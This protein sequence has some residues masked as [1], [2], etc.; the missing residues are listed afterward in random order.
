MSIR[1]KLLLLS[2]VM[3]SIPYVGFQYLRETERYLQSSLEESL[4]SVV[5]AMSISMQF[6]SSIFTNSVDELSSHGGLFVHP[7]GF[8]I[9][10]DGYEDE[11][12]N[13]VGWSESF[14]VG[15]VGSQ[16]LSAYSPSLSRFKL[17]LGE[18]GEYLYALLSV[19]DS[20]IRYADPGKTDMQADAIEVV[21]QNAERE[22]ETLLL[23]PATPG[24]VI[25]YKVVENWDFS[26]SRKTVN[27]VIGAWQ[28]KEG[29]YVVEVRLP[30]H[31]VRS[32]LGFI[33][34]DDVGRDSP[35]NADSTGTS[36]FIA[37]TNGINT[38]SRPNRLLRN[39]AQLKQ[40]IDRVGLK[41]G[42][43]V[44]VLNRNGQVLATSGSLLNE[45]KQGAINFLYTWI[46]P[47]PTSSF[48]DELRRASRLQGAEVL[49]ALNGRAASR[50]RSSP[51][52]RAVIVSAAHPVRAGNELVGA[53]MVEE[54]TNS[55]Q[56]LQRDAMASLYNK[57]ILVIVFATGVIMLFA[58]RL[59]YRILRL[60]NTAESA[61]D[62]QGRIVGDIPES[63]SSDEIGDLSRSFT[64][65]TYRLKEYHDY[66]ESMASKLSHE[67][68]TPISVVSSSLDNLE[69]FELDDEKSRY[70]R[71]VREGVNRLQNLV[72]RLSE[73]ARLEQAISHAEKVPLDLIS[74]LRELAESYDDTYATSTIEFETKLHDAKILG[75]AE[76]ISQLMDKLI[77]NAVQFSDESGRPITIEATATK[78]GFN[79]SVVNAGQALP[80]EMQN[81]IFNSMVSLRAKG[82]NS[83]V[84]LGLGL[85]IVRLIAEYHGG[86][87]SASNLSDRSGVNMTVGFRGQRNA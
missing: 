42:Q 23:K 38:R 30:L 64:A 61:I 11:W 4:G 72:A 25:A 16:N 52:E 2:L 81:Q 83:A 48:E 45:R 67:I 86:T 36:M 18:H 27:N 74:L 29:G 6:Q 78:D 13:Y 47:Q 51:D 50:W 21:Y 70:V 24:A 34:H 69:Q 49:S 7:L 9:Q 71:R 56:T 31:T 3:L 80:E 35:I 76:L 32:L 39:S 8:P 33:V 15:A 17:V 53:V 1:I 82:E 26:R 22:I 12:L 63:S 44:W 85:Y 10:V 87:V 5:S 79:V 19:D 41:Q 60:R 75:S 28:E 55:I 20:A 46:L 40:M 73:S 65:M 37:G 84:H 77:E 59:S 43:R 14:D 62:A 68:R 57:S 58:S 54:T 66:L